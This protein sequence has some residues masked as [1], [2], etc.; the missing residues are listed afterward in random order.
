MAQ[1]D[2]GPWRPDEASVDSNVLV[3]VVNAAPDSTGFRPVGSL[4]ASSDALIED[5]I[6]SAS[7]LDETGS[8]IT[9][10][11]TKSGLFKLNDDR[12]WDDVTNVGGAYTTGSGERWRFAQFGT[13]GIATNFTDPPQK[14]DLTNPSAVFQD[15]GGSPPHARYVSVVGDF[16]QFGILSDGGI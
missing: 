5:C 12:G 2:F 3:D 1:V 9:F 10:A 7:F 16:L 14:I 6:G 11:G 4:A 8:G 15:L 13:L